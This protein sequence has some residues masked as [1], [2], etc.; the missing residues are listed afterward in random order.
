MKIQRREIGND[1]RVS[2]C[3]NV[4][5]SEVRAWALLVSA[6]LLDYVQ[7]LGPR[8]AT[9]AAASFLHHRKLPLNC[10]LLLPKQRTGTMM[11]RQAVS[12]FYD[13]LN[14]V[15]GWACWTC[16]CWLGWKFPCWVLGKGQTCGQRATVEPPF[17]INWLRL[18]S[19]LTNSNLQPKLHMFCAPAALSLSLWCGRG[20]QTI[21]VLVIGH[22][23]ALR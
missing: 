8:T 1:I 19:H 12:S 14:Y 20:K 4:Q 13:M 7:R 18:T 5:I 11:Y 9:A 23:S 3:F 16:C 15:W 10:F 2:D 17:T 22:F 21:F 6:T